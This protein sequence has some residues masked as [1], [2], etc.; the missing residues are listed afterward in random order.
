MSNVS[1]NDFAVRFAEDL[2]IEGE[3]YLTEELSNVKEYDSMAKISVS[4]LIEDI[5]GFQIEYDELDSLNTLISLY[6]Y[7]C[8]Q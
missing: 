4:I 3:Q 8:D 2:N 7:C 6:N 5:W 1:F